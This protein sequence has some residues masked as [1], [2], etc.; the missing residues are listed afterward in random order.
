MPRDN[1]STINRT[2]SPA[3]RISGPDPLPATFSRRLA[4]TII[5]HLIVWTVVAPVAVSVYP[6][7]YPGDPNRDMLPVVL[8]ISAA[9]VLVLYYWLFTGLTGQT[10]GKKLLKTKVVNTRGKRPGL[11]R[12]LWRETMGRGVMLISILVEGLFLII[13]NMSA[14]TL[15][16]TTLITYPEKGYRKP[17]DR[18]PVNVLGFYDRLSGT[19][20]VKTGRSNRG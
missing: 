1:E 9:V 3:G 11:V 18:E 19:R 14:Y 13:S 8:L 10:I 5:D 15:S 20:V 12:A 2:L 16:T 4:A 7:V 17:L 6:L